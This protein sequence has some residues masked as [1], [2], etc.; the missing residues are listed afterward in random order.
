MWFE[1]RKHVGGAGSVSVRSA[2]EW[3]FA[4]DL[5][6]EIRG[7][8]ADPEFIASFLIAGAELLELAKCAGR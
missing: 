5:S 4:L 3:E 1:T 2:E 6:A 8:T 7:L